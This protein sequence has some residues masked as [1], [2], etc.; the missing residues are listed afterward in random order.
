MTTDAVLMLVEEGRLAL[1]AP[2]E[3]C[4]RSRRS[5]AWCALPTPRSPGAVAGDT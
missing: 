2:V 5:R 3:E 4:C 1:E